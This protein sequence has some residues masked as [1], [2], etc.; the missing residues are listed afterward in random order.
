MLNVIVLIG[1]APDQY[2]RIKEF[3]FQLKGLRQNF[4]KGETRL[5]GEIGGT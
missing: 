4:Q 2:K 3:G 5:S 1:M